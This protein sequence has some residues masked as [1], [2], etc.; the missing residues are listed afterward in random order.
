MA[1]RKPRLIVAGAVAAAVVVAVGVPLL[2][3]SPDCP[4]CPP[5]PA[6]RPPTVRA[7]DLVIWFANAP[8]AA[9]PFLLYD[10]PVGHECRKAWLSEGPAAVRLQGVGLNSAC[11]SSLAAFARGRG[12]AAPPTTDLPGILSTGSWSAGLRPPD[13]VH[14]TVWL[15]GDTRP[16]ARLDAQWDSVRDD[17]TLANRIFEDAASGVV[18]AATLGQWQ[19]GMVDSTG[20]TGQAILQ[21]CLNQEEIAGGHAFDPAALNLYYV[22]RISLKTSIGMSCWDYNRAIVLVD[23]LRNKALTLA[24]ELGHA[25]GLVKPYSGHVGQDDAVFP[26]SAANVMVVGIDPPA[27][28]TVGQAFRIQLS[29]S[30]LLNLLAP[31]PGLLSVRC[32]DDIGTDTP[33]P[34]LGLRSPGEAGPVPHSM[35]ATHHAAGPLVDWL[36]CHD[37]S[38]ALLDR[39]VGVL[40][41]LPS[42]TL[43]QLVTY[44]QTGPG[45]QEI[46][47]VDYGLVGSYARDS[48][49]AARSGARAGFPT[50]Q[51]YQA[52]YQRRFERLWRIRAAHALGCALDASGQRLP[53]ATVALQNLAHALA[54]TDTLVTRAVLF[55]RDRLGTVPP[56]DALTG[57]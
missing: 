46:A 16:A 54:A 26:G 20:T 43:A 27:D 9:R 57:P 24:H 7:G 2:F 51:E 30:G 4:G 49:F 32:Q 21:G 31:R 56:C 3:R 44:V 38:K 28:L 53:Q 13:T 6:P 52:R 55:A 40:R 5:R 39:V 1:Q 33:C 34:R 10:G 37:C 11:W 19:Q 48:A 15:V 14:V 42:A 12:P 47:P 18:F 22:P 25:V 41:S 23:Y 8:P 35:P 45:S 36:T 17:V 50:R 29:D